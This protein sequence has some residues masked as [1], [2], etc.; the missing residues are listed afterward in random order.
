MMGA[1]RQ[2][3]ALYS[4]LYLKMIS[5][6]AVKSNH[7]VNTEFSTQSMVY[8]LLINVVAFIFLTCFFEG[9]RHYK[10]IFLKRLQ[11]RFITIGRVPPEPPAQW[12]GWLMAIMNVPEIG[13]TF[14][15]ILFHFLFYFT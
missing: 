14:V 15:F 11:Q 3:F 10:Q 5:S 7:H 2:L 4:F 12:F 13:T 8:T 1:N 9:N 6:S